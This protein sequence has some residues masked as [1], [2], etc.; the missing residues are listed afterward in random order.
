MSEPITL[1][2]TLGAFTIL[3]GLS[4]ALP[5]LATEAG[6]SLVRQ[7][8]PGHPVSLSGGSGNARFR[9]PAQQPPSPARANSRP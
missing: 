1:R 6:L 9:Q 7:P 8:H 4:A 2:R 3:A 5:A